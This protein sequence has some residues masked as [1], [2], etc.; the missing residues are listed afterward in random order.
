MGH[1]GRPL[2]YSYATCGNLNYYSRGDPELRNLGRKLR[3]SWATIDSSTGFTKVA[4][5]EGKDGIKDSSG[6]NTAQYGSIVHFMS[7]LMAYY[8]IGWEFVE[9]SAESLAAHYGD[10]SAITACVHEVAINRT[11]MCWFDSW[12]LDYRLELTTLIPLFDDTMKVM[13]RKQKKKMLTVEKMMQL[14]F[15][16]FTWKLWLV[17]LGQYIFCFLVIFSLERHCNEEDFPDSSLG[18]GITESLYKGILTAFGGGIVLTPK[19]T[20]GKIVMVGMSLSLLVFM[21]IYGAQVTTA[22]V[23]SRLGGSTG[24]MKSFDEGLERGAAFCVYA[25]VA[26]FV[27]ARFPKM[28]IVPVG[29]GGKV[30]ELFDAL[31]E[32]KC[33]GSLITENW[34]T[35]AQTGT[36]SSDK[37]PLYDSVYSKHLQGIEEDGWKRYHCDDKIFP[38]PS[39][40]V[41]WSMGNGI[42]IREELNRLFVLAIKLATD[43]PERKYSKYADM[44]RE[45][46]VPPVQGCQGS[47]VSTDADEDVAAS[48]EDGTGSTII[49]LI[50]TVAGVMHFAIGK[51]I[52]KMHS[53]NF[54]EDEYNTTSQVEQGKEAKC[55]G[56][57]GLTNKVFE[58]KHLD[59][60]DQISRMHQTLE[61]MQKQMGVKKPTPT[62]IIG[63]L[64]LT[65]WNFG[66][67]PVYA[68]LGGVAM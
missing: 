16:P 30:Y 52:Q 7:E 33:E 60:Q 41:P 38:L 18:G 51:I 6:K 37:S 58:A 50:F 55:G 65:S 42:P 35:A 54:K 19:T 59:L 4:A 49:T 9:I 28:N 1:N 20:P 56:E 67:S 68:E 2:S 31:Y 11:D 15:S 13:V 22:L 25:S 53:R 63:D 14:P 40:N 5:L 24:A 12:L 61:S 46:L 48:L 34:W 47:G 36:F 43:D 8:G 62:R 32:G 27:Q 29:P 26:P 64:T 21:S 17:V 39:L 57:T 3:V 45:K 44:Y 23:E 66:P 10:T